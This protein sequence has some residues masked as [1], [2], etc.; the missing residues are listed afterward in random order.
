MTT[1]NSGSNS[2]RRTPGSSSEDT[3]SFI[4]DGPGDNTSRPPRPLLLKLGLAERE[5]M[6]RYKAMMEQLK[7]Q[8]QPPE[9]QGGPSPPSKPA[10]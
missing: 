3:V 8:Q 1:N 10:E 4:D 6:A 9:N 5:K 7:Q 2:P